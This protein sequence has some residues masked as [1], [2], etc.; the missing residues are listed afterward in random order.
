MNYKTLC[1]DASATRAGRADYRCSKCG[2]DVTI[3]MIFF[4][5]MA[6]RGSAMQAVKNW[7]RKEKA[8]K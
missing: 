4:Y 5:D 1:C 7:R 8:A 3:E 2:K 6:D